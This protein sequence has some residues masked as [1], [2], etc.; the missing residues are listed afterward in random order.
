[1]R[2]VF[3]SVRL[4]IIGG[5]VMGEALL[6]RLLGQGLY[7]AEEVM[8]SEP[9]PKR[10]QVLFEQYSIKTTDSN[11]EVLEASEVVL[12]AIKPQVFDI[13]AKDFQG[14]RC[15]T[16]PLVLSIL[17]GV[18]LSKL[19]SVMAG[20]PVVR[21]MPNT[22]A[23][24]GSGMT[25]IAL[26][27]RTLAE[28]GALAQKIFA[29]MGQVVKVPEGMLDAVT[30]L[31]GSGPGYVAIVI[32]ALADGGVASGLPRAIAN[33]LALQT[34]LGTAELLQKTGMHPAELKDRVTSPG[35]TTIAGIACLEELGL[36]SALIES[37]RTASSR[38]RELGR[39]ANGKP[40]S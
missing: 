27:T 18:P 26:G 8:L 25:A 31:S 29:A 20:W 16:P 2:A 13:V 30:G 4:G 39:P 1:M 36:R 35:G 3:L 15:E 6:S 17:A 37:V 23:T 32:E 19:E 34:V 14:V 24:V 28:H 21:A 40:P 10:R 9:A 33:Q 11:R 7:A 38:S 22:P 12:L 5:G